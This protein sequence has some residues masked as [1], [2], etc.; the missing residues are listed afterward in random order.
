[1]TTQQATSDSSVPAAS[2]PARP[3]QRAIVVGA[4]SGIGA[5]LVKR[6]VDQGWSVAALARRQD[7]LAELEESLKA[8]LGQGDARLIVRAHDVQDTPA[9]QPLV[10]E[11]VEE[12]GGLDLMIFAAGVMPEIERHEYPTEK[13]LFMLSVNVGGCIAW[14]N[15]VAPLLRTQGFGTICGISS[16]AG[17]RGR[18]G[19]PVYCTTKAAMDTYLEALRNRLAEDG[20]HVCTIK[21][22]FV[23]TVMTQGM[24]GLFW[25]ASPEEAARKILAAVKS[26]ANV[27]YVKRRW[28]L[29][30]RVIKSIPSF[31]FRHLN[32]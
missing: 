25:M 7:K 14:C 17:D 15:G 1:M 24:D 31:L 30:G 2:H 28:W 4:S 18:K 16:I 8:R 10:E 6:L 19:N 23:D 32:I 29:V 27:R 13:D 22:G 12:L 3:G 26:R 5:A 11:L 21:P 20:V 9:V